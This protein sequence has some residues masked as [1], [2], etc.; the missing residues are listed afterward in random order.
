MAS[1]NKESLSKKVQKAQASVSKNQTKK[2]GKKVAK[3]DSDLSKLPKKLL[4]EIHNDMVKSRV[5]EERMIKIYKMGDAYFWIGG[6]GEE[7]FGVT[8][9][10]LARKGQGPD[11][12][13]FHL[14][15]RCSPTLVAL[16]MPMV[17][18]IRLIMNKATDIHTGGRNF[19]N[20]LCYPEWNVAPVSSPIEVQYSIGIGTAHVQKR[21]KSKG[22]T[23][24][25]GGDAGSAEGDFASC[26]IW[27]SRKD[28]ELPMLITVQNNRWGISTPYSE[29]HG[30]ERIA[31]RGKAFG[32]R[33]AVINGNDVVES[34]LRMKEEMDY[35]RKTG[36]PVLLEADVSRL[37][38][39]SSASGANFVTEE[40]CCLNLF[41]QRLIE[42]S[43]ITEKDC[44]KIWT[45]YDEESKRLQE[46]VRAEADPS[47]DTLW[48][49]VY[50]N[51]ENANWRDF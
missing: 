32:I 28:N 39:H 17:D 33:T 12:D 38:G 50:V 4:L 41:Q 37:Y 47:P 44:K 3:K 20:H 13:Y 25:T 1:V 35:I 6:P 19:A 43:L 34:Y 36:K 7:A 51:G 46:M 9:G 8:L 2:P 30:E 23:I 42:A 27:A 29:S 10:K 11:S 22:I 48:D 31:D 18:G 15:Y 40:D 14:H 26:L 49:H 45:D 5:L 21:K 24:I 16:G